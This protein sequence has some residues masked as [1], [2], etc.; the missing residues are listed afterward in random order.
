MKFLGERLAERAEL[1]RMLML[2]KVFI[3]QD[4]ESGIPTLV[5]NDHAYANQ[6]ADVY[7]EINGRPYRVTETPFIF[8]KEPEKATRR[9]IFSPLKRMWRNR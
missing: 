3:I 8:K 6:L 4:V 5:V 2:E 1:G 9:S 7:E